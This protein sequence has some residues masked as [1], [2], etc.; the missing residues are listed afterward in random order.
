MVGGFNVYP[1]EVERILTQHPAVV[2]AQVVGVPDARLGEIPVAFV[3]LRAENHEPTEEE[4]LA[5]CEERLSGYKVPRRIH[6]IDAFPTNSA[7]KIEKYR[8]RELAATAS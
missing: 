6:V 8:L 7:G 4:L 1:A 5:F 2:Q 3:R